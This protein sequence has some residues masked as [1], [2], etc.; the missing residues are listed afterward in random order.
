MFSKREEARFFD[1]F[2]LFV[3]WQSIKLKSIDFWSVEHYNKI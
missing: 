2:C 1:H 3:D